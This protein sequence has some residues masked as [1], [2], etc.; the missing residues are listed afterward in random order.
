MKF[1]VK[2]F[3]ASLIFTAFVSQAFAQNKGN[4]TYP[5]ALNWNLQSETLQFDNA[6]YKGD[7]NFLPFYGYSFSS[8]SNDVT[9][10][11]SDPV[12][13][14]IDSKKLNAEQIKIIQD[15]LLT[16]TFVGLSKNTFIH[17]F[18]VLPF[19]TKNGQLEILTSF[20][21]HVTLNNNN[22]SKIN[23]INAFTYADHSILQNGSFYKIGVQKEG[24]YKLDYTFLKNLGIAVDQINPNSIRIYGHRA[25][26]LPELAGADRE[27]DAREIPI[28]LV[29]ASST[30]FRNGDYILAYLPG[31]ESWTYNASTQFFSSTKHL[32]SDTKYFFIGVDNGN[33]TKISLRNSSSS[34]PNQTFSTYNDYAS[35]EDDKINIAHSGR[36]FLGDEF[37]S[38]STRNYSFLFPNINTSFPLKV[39][40]ACAASALV[41]GANFT[42]Q[43]NGSSQNINLGN[44]GN[45]YPDI[46][47]TAS[48]RQQLYSYAANSSNPQFSLSF[49][50]NGD[51]NT[52][53]WLDY[54][55]VNAVS[56]L[57][58]TNGQLLF[59][60]ASSIGSGNVSKFTIQNMNSG[61][62]IWDITNPFDVQ[63]IN[64]NLTGNNADFTIE[65]DSL[66][67]FALV[68]NSG[69]TPLAFGKISNQDLHALPQQDMLIITRKNLKA[70]AE[71]IAQ[72]HRNK[73]GLRVAVVDMEDI[74][75]EFSSATP[76]IS[77]IRNFIKMFYDRATGASNLQPKYVLLFGDG[78]Y[79]NKKLG[80]YL[81]PTYQS[82]S[83]FEA[84]ST[85][86][87]DDFYGCLNDNEGADI[88]N[89]ALNLMD[90]AVGRIPVANTED[91]DVA[92]SKITSYTAT[93]S[94]GE[95]RNQSTF[96]ADDED[97][98]LHL[99]DAEDLANAYSAGYKCTNMD[100]IYLDAYTQQSGTGGAK[101]PDV[102]TAI[103]RKF[104]TGS[105]FLNYMGHGG[106]LGLSKEGILSLA[107]I[108][109]WN[110]PNKLSYFI[111]ATCEFTPYDDINIT[112]AGEH[113]LL[114]PSG[115]AIGL[116]STTRL[117]IASQNKL[118]NSNFMQKMQLASNTLNMTIGD[119]CRE[120]KIITTSTYEG[121]RKFALFGDP[122]LRPAFPVNK[123][124]VTM[125]DSV[126][127]SL[128]T[129]SIKALSKIRISGEI[130]DI[131][132][133]FMPT[134]NGYVSII[135][136][137]KPKVYHT[138]Q[139]DPQSIAT[140]FTIQKNAIYKGRTRVVNGKYEFVFLVPRD[141]DYNYGLGKISLYANNDTTDAC[142]FYN[143]VVV[144]G[145][146][147]TVISDNK[148]P[149]VD[150]FMND[151]KFVFGGITDNNPLLFAKLFDE[152]GINTSGTGIGH[153]ITAVIDNDMRT[154]YTLNDFYEIDADAINKGTVKF[155]FSSLSDGRHTLKLTAWDILNNSGSGYTEFIVE[156]SADLALAHILNYPNPFTTSTNFMFEHNKPGQ[157]LA[158]KIE[159]F[160]VSGKI[161]KTILKN[162]NTVGYR[163]NDIFWDGKDDYGDK[164]GRGV[165]I[166]RITV[167]DDSGKKSQQYQKLVILN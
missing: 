70:Q 95:W 87:S 37:G 128:P 66:K 130:H 9:F 112:S 54:L 107:D 126:S 158:V 154:V 22:S 60:N 117:V 152:N 31:P 71:G 153:D 125:I 20:V 81:L 100:K 129:D 115:G 77:A 89:T 27:T 101:Y 45:P 105:L 118:I 29:S 64:A 102:N 84:L 161:V 30:A 108:E 147:D 151:D 165:Y 110:N 78:T 8:S 28:K 2:I 98:N 137:D 99:D 24:I 13:S 160:S 51:Y 145:A 17:T 49:E 68:D 10:F 144:G 35:I 65:T 143:Q 121:N 140:D 4:Q 157:D 80:D 6:N 138:L 114:R 141:I 15:E 36:I 127:T 103:D 73:Q 86:V 25:G 72:Y 43:N 159:I 146:Y 149:D 162:I 16:E 56:N 11:I 135:V 104:Y 74:F 34:T 67:Q 76:D 21:L 42:L 166:Y 50:R 48:Y 57:Q 19:R 142:G 163:V 38:T 14:P 91:A 33:S 94:F 26:M 47:N 18:Q 148:G 55:Q 93:P 109:K 79:E 63:K 41:V 5:I 58:Y 167:K 44:V 7:W 139:N 61:V 40:I 106:P 123:C 113:M 85:Y 1:F 156:K 97:Y 69:L 59:R 119:I 120:A 124:V 39:S 53:G 111:T 75:N 92:L 90:V 164:I 136:Y 82:R 122:A 32:Y 150:L 62:E 23:S 83:T 3:T 12:F 116:L 46:Y 96:I 132:N 134:F 133:A 131:N 155:P 88:T 52:K